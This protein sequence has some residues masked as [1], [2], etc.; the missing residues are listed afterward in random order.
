MKLT[1]SWHKLANGY[2]VACCA[3]DRNN[4]HGK[5]LLAQ[6]LDD[7][8]GLGRDIAINW[9]EEGK[10]LA[11]A[12]LA[13]ASGPLRWQREYFGLEFDG[14]RGIAFDLDDPECT[15]QLPTRTLLLLLQHWQDFLAAGPEAG[16]KTIEVEAD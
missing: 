7:D 15:E 13:G 11:N 4:A 16:A 12:A 9:I 14:D 6:A 1:F 10:R 3:S 8:G 5:S 2:S